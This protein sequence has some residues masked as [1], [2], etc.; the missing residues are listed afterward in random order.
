MREENGAIEVR[1]RMVAATVIFLCGMSLALG[2]L[3]LSRVLAALLPALGRF[4]LWGAVVCAGLSLCVLLAALCIRMVRRTS[5]DLTRGTVRTRSSVYERAQIGDIV[6]RSN[7]IMDQE[8]LTIVALTPTAERVLVSGHS[9]KHRT[10][11]TRVL[12]RMRM[13]VGVGSADRQGRGEMTEA[14]RP[15]SP[16]LG[17]VPGVV[18]IVLGLVISLSGYAMI[19]DLLLTRPPF[20]FGVL[21]WPIGI[22]IAIAGADVL[23]AASECGRHF[24][25]RRKIVW[26][27]LLVIWLVSYFAICLRRIG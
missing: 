13:L 14:A 23:M 3:F 26:M 7:R 12:Q 11:M 22:W 15:V 25:R 27:I 10:D 5:L 20:D 2:L 8:I 16:A 9:R 18:V 21:F 17:R 19:P 6:L 24:Y 1:P 4:A